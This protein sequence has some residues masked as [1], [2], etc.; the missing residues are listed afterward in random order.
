M[1]EMSIALSLL[2]LAEAE[3]RKNNC[4]QI[5]SI[6]VE[7]G[8]LSGIM[9]ES[10]KFCFEILT[11]DGPHKGAKLEL[12]EIPVTLRCPSCNS[13]FRNND[14]P[15]ILQSCPQCGALSGLNVEQGKELLLLRLEANPDVS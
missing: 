7:Y 2:E 10:L 5:T 11:A 6:T 8:A 13:I 14:I 9:P 1:H 15:A 3:A 4:K 12:I